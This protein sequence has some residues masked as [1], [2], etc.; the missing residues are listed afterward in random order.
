[1][2]GGTIPKECTTGK[3]E[4][5]QTGGGHAPII[6][7][8]R[9]AADRGD[10]PGRESAEHREQRE[11]LNWVLGRGASNEEPLAMKQLA[12]TIKEIDD[13][14]NRK[15]TIGVKAP[16]VWGQNRMTKYNAEFENVMAENKNGFHS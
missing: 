7:E 13:A 3:I 5:R 2:A 1:M 4:F 15:G 6:L 16:D 12:H 14:L 8:P 10:R 11:P 9:A